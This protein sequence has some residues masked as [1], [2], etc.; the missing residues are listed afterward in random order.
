MIRIAVSN[1]IAA[2]DAETPNWRTQATNY[3]NE[4]IRT[5][6]PF[7]D[8]PLNNIR[9]PDWSDIKPAFLKLQNYKCAYCERALEEATIEWDV[10]HFR[11][12]NR[13]TPWLGPPR[14]PG[15]G[16]ST[17]Y[18]WLAYNIE[19]YCVAC[20][21]CNSNLKADHFPISGRAGNIHDD[22]STLHVV[23]QPLLLFPFG[24]RDVDPETLIGWNGTTPIPLA[25]SGTPEHR[26]AQ[27]TIAFFKL[28]QRPLIDRE[29]AMLLGLLWRYLDIE[30]DPQ[31]PQAERDK[32]KKTANNFLKNPKIQMRAC[33][34]AF[35][36]MARKN[37]AG[38]LPLVAALELLYA[39]DITP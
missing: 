24:N 22:I 5:N 4:M 26:R 36:S 15:H 12:K 38:V 11:P 10:E 18:Y 23:E 13:V 17:G 14:P 30:T 21:T 1:L 25:Q 28:D 3:T 29:R 20:K 2:V 16:L 19:N 6:G 8:K 34:R 9:A 39:P 35:A 27:T 33:L 37:R 31:K 7:S 32:A